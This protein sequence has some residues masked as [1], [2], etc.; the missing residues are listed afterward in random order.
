VV[1][2]A[3]GGGA[4]VS[5]DVAT[6]GVKPLPPLSQASCPVWSAAR[7]ALG[8]DQPVVSNHPGIFGDRQ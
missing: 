6:T 7:I 4:T 8:V 2:A 3:S 5:K 1:E